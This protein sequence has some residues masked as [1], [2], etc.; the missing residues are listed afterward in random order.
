MG[1]KRE[2]SLRNFTTGKSHVFAGEY[3]ERIPH[4]RPRYIDKFDEP[5]LAGRVEV[6]VT[7]KKVLVGTELHMVQAGLPDIIPLEACYLGWQESLQNLAGLVEPEI[8]P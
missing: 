3:L 5:N 2:M 4:H 8:A 1:G 6:T 7:F